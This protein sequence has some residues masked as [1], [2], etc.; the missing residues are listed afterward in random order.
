M[1]S[2]FFEAAFS[3]ETAAHVLE[4]STGLKGSRAVDKSCPS[5]FVTSH[6]NSAFCRSSPDGAPKSP[7]P[8]AL[9]VVARRLHLEAS[10]RYFR[11]ERRKYERVLFGANVTR[12]WKC[13]P[14]LEG[15][16]PFLHS[17]RNHSRCV[18]IFHSQVAEI[19]PDTH[20][21]RSA[22]VTPGSKGLVLTHAVKR[23]ML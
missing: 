21:A 7:S 13:E 17:D 2:C 8:C 20:Q 22:I 23:P 14:D 10:V 5:L 3:A 9:G 16:W 4:A 11:A 19:G 12:R 15:V 1:T 18:R 6:S